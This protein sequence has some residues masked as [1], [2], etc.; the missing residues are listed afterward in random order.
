VDYELS[1]RNP[2]RIGERGQR[3]LPRVK[4]QRTFLEIDEF[5][6]LPLCQGEVRQILLLDY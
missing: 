3:F 4:P 1:E 6:A 2:V 5:H